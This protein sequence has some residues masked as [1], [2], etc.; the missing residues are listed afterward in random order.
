M[1]REF[2]EQRETWTLNNK[3][4][5]TGHFE[6]D[7]KDCENVIFEEKSY[8]TRDVIIVEPAQSDSSIKILKTAP[9]V[10]D[11]KI[12]LYERPL[13]IEEQKQIADKQAKDFERQIEESE[14]VFK[15]IPYEILSQDEIVEKMEENGVTNFIDPHFPPRDISLYNVIKEK[16]PYSSILCWR[17]P[18]EFMENPSLFENDIDPNDIKQGYLGDC[19]FMSA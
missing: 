4:L 1:I 5:S 9:Y 3:G 17:R 15:K 12:R 10:F 7:L 13:P 8:W 18:H 2:D 11:F 6:I 19:W 14:R 16:Y